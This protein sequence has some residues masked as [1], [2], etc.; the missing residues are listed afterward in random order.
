MRR[1]LM[2]FEPSQE[3]ARILNVLKLQAAKA[4]NATEMTDVLSA[5]ASIPWRG[6]REK[7]NALQLVL[8]VYTQALGKEGDSV[9]AEAKD[10]KLRLLNDRVLDAV[11]AV[12]YPSQVLHNAQLNKNHL[13]DV[14]TLLSAAS[15]RQNPRFEEAWLLLATTDLLRHQPAQRAEVHRFLQA[16]RRFP[17]L[18]RSRLV[19]A[20]AVD[21]LSAL[22]RAVPAGEAGRDEQTLVRATLDML[23]MWFGAEAADPDICCLLLDTK[24]FLSSQLGINCDFGPNALS[25]LDTAFQA[26]SAEMGAAHPKVVALMSRWQEYRSRLPSAA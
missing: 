10:A 26:L 8:S 21:A 16:A 4:V 25:M 1:A 9:L 3:S 20:K 24:L 5:I 15:D 22:A 14:T 2:D 11:R 19:Q 6:F 7:D 23:A 12:G 17:G 18:A 13:R